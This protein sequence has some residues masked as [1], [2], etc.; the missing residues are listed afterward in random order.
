MP[1]TMKIAMI[2]TPFYTRTG[3]ERQILTLAV[4]L[5][6]FGHQVEIFTGYANKSTYPELFSKLKVNVIPIDKRLPKYI[7]LNFAFSMAKIATKISKDFEIINN[8]NFPTEWAAFFAKK[9]LK[10]PVVWM[11]NEPPF[12]YL[13]PK[14]RRGLAKCGWPLYLFD[15]LTVKHI[16]EILSLSNIGSKIIYDVYHRPSTVVRTGV[17]VDLFH[18]ASGDEFRK[19]HG[20]ENCYVLLQVGSFIYYKR[21]EDSIMA[22]ADVSKKHD[23]VKLVLDGV[24]S[25]ERLRRLARKLGVEDKIIFVHATSDEEIAATYAACDVFLYPSENTWG[26][27]TVEAMAASKPVIVS[28]KNGT[29]EII[30][31]DMGFVI[32]HESPAEM[33]NCI[34]YLIDNPKRATELGNNCH[35]YVK[36]NLSWDKYARTIENVFSRLIK[37]KTP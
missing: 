19:K 10:I 7:D 13:H 20:L 11:C 12:W 5:Q 3:G 22:L 1:L 9:R 26:L 21:Q 30:N 15:K 27:V 25:P 33:A 37:E 34:R 36:E 14:E 6:N 29:A 28:N 4:K 24:G 35:Q 18:N 2:H 8:H 16:D 17:N 31:E 32:N 23:N